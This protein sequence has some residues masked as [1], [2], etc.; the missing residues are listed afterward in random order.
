MLSQPGSSVSNPSPDDDPDI[1]VM[2][3]GWISVTQ[4]AIQTIPGDLPFPTAQQFLETLGTGEWHSVSWIESQLKERGFEDINVRSV[5]KAMSIKVPNF[6]EMTMIMFSM[7]SKAF[8]TE[9]QRQEDTEKVRPALEK[10]LET[11][12]G[13]EGDIPMEWTAILSTA[14]KS[15][16]S[17]A[18]AKAHGHGL[19][20]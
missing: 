10:Y 5:T 11:T 8:W 12:Y 4:K 18:T 13:K 19:S 3:A 16:E 2:I 20:L 15:D 6:V 9:K 1:N 7:V 17:V 14:R